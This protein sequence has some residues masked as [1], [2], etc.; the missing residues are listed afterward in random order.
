VRRADNVP[1]SCASIWKFCERQPPGTLR[2][3][4]GPYR[5]RVFQVRIQLE[6]SVHTATALVLHRRELLEELGD[7]QCLKHCTV[8]IK[9]FSAGNWEK[10]KRYLRT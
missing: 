7:Y 9:E 3:C 10:Q 1:H 6:L 4:P 5:E 2:A 8:Y